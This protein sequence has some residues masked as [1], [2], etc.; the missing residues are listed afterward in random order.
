MDRHTEGAVKLR[1]L[2]FHTK[3]YIQ[4][5]GGGDTIN[6]VIIKCLCDEFSITNSSNIFNERN[7]LVPAKHGTQCA[8]TY[9]SNWMDNLVS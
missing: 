9:W 4:S 2:S 3:K 7:W 6:Q 1:Y 8:Y 5:V